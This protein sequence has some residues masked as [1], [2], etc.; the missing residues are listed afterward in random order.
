MGLV[1]LGNLLTEMLTHRDQKAEEKREQH[2]QKKTQDLL[3]ASISN[4]SL[5]I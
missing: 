5:S 2:Q 3:Y 4:T 1:L